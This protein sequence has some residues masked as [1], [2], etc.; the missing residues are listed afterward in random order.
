MTDI[1]ASIVVAGAEFM[2]SGNRFWLARLCGVAVLGEDVGS[3]RARGVALVGIDG[4]RFEGDDLRLE[5]VEESDGAVVYRWR[6]RPR[7]ASFTLDAEESD[8]AVVCRWRVGNTPARLTTRWHADSET[9]IVSRRDSITN[10]SDAPVVVTRCLAR[11]AFPPGQY[12]CYTQTSRWA[13][14]NQGG[15]QP[16]HAGIALR[17]AWGRTTEGSTPYLAIR[18]CGSQEG[19][20]FHVLP[21]GNWTVRVSTVTEGGDLPCAVVELGLADENLR[22]TLGPGATFDLPEVLC[23][24]LSSGEPH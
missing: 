12:E 19:I 2:F 21:L 6:V 11:I 8:G 3:P 15:W 5:W 9:G 23:Q 20:A 22:R 1:A 16:L 10:T 14:E 17:H 24:P 4:R 13:H 7:S 18:R